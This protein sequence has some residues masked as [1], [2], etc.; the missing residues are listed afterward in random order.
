MFKK[1][2]INEWLVL[3]LT[4]GIWSIAFSSTASQD[5]VI[6]WGYTLPS[7]C[8]VINLF[9]IEC[10]GCGLTRSVVLAVNGEIIPSAK[11]HLMGIPTLLILTFLS[12]KY[13]KI[14][15]NHFRKEETEIKFE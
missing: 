8:I 7:L 14:L 6:I 13:I 11:M 5:E 10:L 3:F 1:L 12:G 2:H 15:L 4:T 9:G